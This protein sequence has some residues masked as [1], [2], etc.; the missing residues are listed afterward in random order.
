MENKKG[1]K[2]FQ[3][4]KEAQKE[5]GFEFKGCLNPVERVKVVLLVNLAIILRLD[6]PIS[7]FCNIDQ[8]YSALVK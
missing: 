5:V 3:H 6:M 2:K 4:K 1:N 8:F 7:E